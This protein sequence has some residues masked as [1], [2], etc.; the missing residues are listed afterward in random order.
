MA[1]I[2]DR[3]PNR[4]NAC[5]QGRFHRWQRLVMDEWKDYHDKVLRRATWHPEGTVTLNF[6]LVIR[7]HSIRSKL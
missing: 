4:G 6:L 3:V 1:Q 5:R 2:A 7:G